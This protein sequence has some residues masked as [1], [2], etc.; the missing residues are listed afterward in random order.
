MIFI[1]FIPYVHKVM[2]VRISFTR[3]P[4]G[5]AQQPERHSNGVKVGGAIPSAGQVFL[6][7]LR[8]FGYCQIDSPNIQGAED[9]ER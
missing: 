1:S 7:V 2:E 8:V 6:L 5:I 9:D 4:S 3:R